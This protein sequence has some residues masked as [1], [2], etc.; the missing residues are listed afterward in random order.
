MRKVLIFSLLLFLI[1]QC[2]DYLPPFY[3]ANPGFVTK[4]EY[5]KNNHQQY[6]TLVIG[7]SRTYRQV[8]PAVFD[9][10]NQKQTATFNLAMSGALALE[11]FAFLDD[12]LETMIVDNKRFILVE[13]QPFNPIPDENLHAART[14][15]F[16]DYRWYRFAVDYFIERKDLSYN[17]KEKIIKDYTISYIERILKIGLLKGMMNAMVYKK[18]DK[19][20]LGKNND[21]YYAYSDQIISEKIKGNKYKRDLLIQ[22][23]ENF[24][25]DRTILD[26]VHQT[27]KEVYEKRDFYPVSKAYLQQVNYVFEKA[28][29]KNIHLIFFLPPRLGSVY[30]NLLPIFQQ[31]PENHRLDMANPFHYPEFYDIAYSFDRG[32]LNDAGAIVFSQ[33][34]ATAL[35]P[36]LERLASSRK[37]SVDHGTVRAMGH[38]S[39]VVSGTGLRKNP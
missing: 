9:S 25:E 23:Y 39:D 1:L 18:L 31:I 29:K 7:S 14:K 6:N 32:H 22:K 11:A 3:Y 21:G 36:I 12:L 30:R 20:V 28:K 19:S 4:M 33:K 27:T 16:L 38:L 24:L 37:I 8:V 5:L 34:L 35:H 26:D 10:L 15:Y 13:L 17:E 2:V